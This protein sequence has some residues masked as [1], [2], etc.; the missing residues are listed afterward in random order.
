MN[1]PERYKNLKT[2]ANEFMMQG[3]LNEYLKVIKELARIEN[4][5]Y[6]SL[7]WN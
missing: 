3:L 4:Q 6:R 1:L 7:R 2:K 5:L